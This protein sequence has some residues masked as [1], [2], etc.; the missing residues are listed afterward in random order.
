MPGGTVEKWTTRNATPSPIST[1]A[2]RSSTCRDGAGRSGTVPRVTAHHRIHTAPTAPSVR[3]PHS[4]RSSAN[5]KANCARQ[6]M[7]SSATATTH[8]TTRPTVPLIA[9]AD[10]S[11]APRKARMAGREVDSQEAC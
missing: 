1:N 7:T 10:V 6:A 2:A 4:V 9:R 11:G 5:W 3:Q 8:S